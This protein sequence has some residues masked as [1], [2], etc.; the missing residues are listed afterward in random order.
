MGSFLR[1]HPFAVGLSA[2]LH[3]LLAAALTA[4]FDP[5][6]RR[7]AAVPSEQMAIQ[8]TVVDESLIQAELER[9][10]RLEQEELQRQQEEARLAQEQAEAARREREEEERRLEAARQQAAEEA[11]QEEVRLAELQR[12]REEEATRQRQEAEESARQEQERLAALER[13][14]QEAEEAA[15]R[16]QER[17][18]ELERQRQAEEERRRQAA[19]RQQAELEAE[20]QRALAAEDERRRAQEAGLLDEYIRLIENRIQQNWIPPASA[21]A[22]LECVVNVTQIP[23]GDVVDVRIGRCNG[24]EAVVRSI[25]AAVLRSSPL[26]RPPIPALFERNLEV[27]FN[28]E[29]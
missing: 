9:L 14:R 7:R 10:E 1:Q 23:S 29:V 28:P 6:G 13:Q 20:L 11:R 5:S 24:D 2:L 22:G 25:E 19:A 15:R 12:Q 8:A 17:L 4:G 18:A 27:V 21:T 16:E 3:V 26:P